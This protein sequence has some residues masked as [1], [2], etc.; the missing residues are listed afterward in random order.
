MLYTSYPSND[1]YSVAAGFENCPP[2]HPLRKAAAQ[3]AQ[4]YA[5][6]MAAAC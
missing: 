2:D 4:T 3:L 5:K 6:N 1:S